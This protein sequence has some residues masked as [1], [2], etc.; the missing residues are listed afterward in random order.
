VNCD[1]INNKD[2]ITIDV[3]CKCI[4]SDVKYHT[5]KVLIVECILSIKLKNHSFPDICLY[6]LFSLC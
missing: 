2:S 4:M 1:L 5:V 6:Q 3:C